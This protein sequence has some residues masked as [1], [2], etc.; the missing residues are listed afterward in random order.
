M[1]HGAKYGLVANGCKSTLR[2]S[3]GDREEL[4]FIFGS[5]GVEI[6]KMEDGLTYPGFRLKLNK[7][8]VG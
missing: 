2:Y 3:N 4:E 7:Y 6:K 1:R 8:R 5:F